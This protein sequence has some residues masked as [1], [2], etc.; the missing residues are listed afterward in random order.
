MGLATP[1]SADRQWRLLS[2]NSEQCCACAQTAQANH[3]ERRGK[4]S[5]SEIL[6]VSHC[7]MTAGPNKDIH[8]LYCALL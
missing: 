4:Q 6:G 5:A 2:D 3:G 1:V 7:S 8:T